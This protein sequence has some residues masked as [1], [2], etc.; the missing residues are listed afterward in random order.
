MFVFRFVERADAR[1]FCCAV[2]P[3]LGSVQ[4]DG[5]VDTGIDLNAADPRIL[6]S[7]RAVRDLAAFLGFPVPEEHERL[8]GELEGAVRELA[9]ARAELEE[10][11]REVDAIYVMKSRGWK[12]AGRPGR[13]PKLRADG[14]E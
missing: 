1:P 3:Q 12:P 8:A 13:P 2:Y 4:Q 11:R 6:V 14:D 9:E 7:V 5:Y 10:L